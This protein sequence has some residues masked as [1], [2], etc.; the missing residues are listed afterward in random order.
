MCNLCATLIHHT[1]SME[2]RQH[3]TP[4]SDSIVIDAVIFGIIFC[5][6]CVRGRKINNY[7]AEC[8]DSDIVCHS[9]NSHIHCVCYSCRHTCIPN[10][11]IYV[12]FSIRQRIPQ[13]CWFLF[14][15]IKVEYFIASGWMSDRMYTRQWETFHR[16]TN[17]LIT[18]DMKIIRLQ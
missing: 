6:C 3:T 5:C 1:K 2:I 8:I 4:I 13:F 15:N 7:S 16:L 9:R 18:E 17:Y 14:I 12:C 11:C 10:N